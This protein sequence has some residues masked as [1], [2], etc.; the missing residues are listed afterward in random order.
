MLDDEVDFD[1][2]LLEFDAVDDEIE[3]D[4]TKV[5]QQMLLLVEVDDD[6]AA[7]Q[8]VQLENDEMV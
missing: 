4:D 8:V 7:T 6:E 3:G 2:V 1:I 5:R